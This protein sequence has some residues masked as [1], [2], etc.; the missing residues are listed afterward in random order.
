MIPTMF[1]LGWV[2]SSTN[3]TELVGIPLCPDLLRYEQMGEADHLRGRIVRGFFWL[4]R[5][6]P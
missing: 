4:L 3:V 2:G 6:W 1:P 5:W